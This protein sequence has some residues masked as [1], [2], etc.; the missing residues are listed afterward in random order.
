MWTKFR[1]PL[2][3]SWIWQDLE[4]PG[5]LF[6]KELKKILTFLMFFV[7]NVKESWRSSFFLVEEFER[8]W[9]PLVFLFRIWMKIRDLLC[10]VFGKSW[11]KPV[12]IFENLIESSAPLVFRFLFLEGFK[13]SWG[14][15]RSWSFF[16]QSWRSLVFSFCKSLKE[17]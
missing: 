15:R 3:S 12:F 1:D 4:T 6:L 5:V 14:A 8:S 9:R 2:C 7:K 16:R 11:K 17:S 13:R 10:F